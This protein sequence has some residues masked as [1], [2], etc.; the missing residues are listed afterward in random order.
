MVDRTSLSTTAR[1][2]NAR[3][4]A[5]CNQNTDPDMDLRSKGR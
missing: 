5:T 2:T 4:E 1:C 3:D